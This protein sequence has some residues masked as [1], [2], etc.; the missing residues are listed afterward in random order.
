[1]DNLGDFLM[2]DTIFAPFPTYQSRG[3]S[4]MITGLIWKPPA[5]AAAIM[6]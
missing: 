1:M 4:V 3:G 5:A 2:T 6:N